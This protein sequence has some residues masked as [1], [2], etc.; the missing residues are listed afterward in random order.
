LASYTNADI[1]TPSCAWSVIGPGLTLACALADN[2]K[3]S[4][5]VALFSHFSNILRLPFSSRLDHRVLD[6]FASSRVLL[7]WRLS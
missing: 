3:A 2:Q 4:T 6:N 5:M 7:R 1:D